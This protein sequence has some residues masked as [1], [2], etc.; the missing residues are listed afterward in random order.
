MTEKIFH[1]DKSN[2]DY[3]VAPYLTDRGTEES[4]IHGNNH[5]Y[6]LPDNQVV[7]VDVTDA[8]L[9]KIVTDNLHHNVLT[10]LEALLKL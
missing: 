1:T 9:I 7:K 2:Y 10:E 5:F 8:K 3:W 6:F 4:I